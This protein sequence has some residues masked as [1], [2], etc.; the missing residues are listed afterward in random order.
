MRIQPPTKMQIIFHRGAKIKEHPK[1]KLVNDKA[2]ML[3]W[4]GNDRA[5]ATFRNMQDIENGK[6]HLERI[7]KEW[8]NATRK[9]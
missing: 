8:I 5:I 1:E 9:K 7:V 2:G 3:A 6:T 4:K